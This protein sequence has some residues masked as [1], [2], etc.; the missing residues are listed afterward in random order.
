[1]TDLPLTD[2][3]FDSIMVTVDHGLSKGIIL[4]PCTKKGLMAERTAEIFIN[5]VFSRFGLPEKLMT[6]RGVQFDSEFF[7]EICRLLGVRTSMTTT[8]H[9]Q[10]NG[11]T[12]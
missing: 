4:S 1:M 11:G 2:E 8:F 7:K 12:E 9:P 10:A 3:G 6:D 5:D